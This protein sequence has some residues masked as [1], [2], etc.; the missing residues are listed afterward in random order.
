MTQPSWSRVE[1]LD[2]SK[3]AR[4]LDIDG[5]ASKWTD[6]DSAAILRHQLAAP[7]L[8][9]LLMVP[10]AEEP[11]LRSLLTGRPGTNSFL[12]QLTTPHPSLEL[13]QAI[14]NF[15]RHVHD[16]PENPLQGGPSDVLYFASIAA[17]FA[18]CATRITRLENAALH[19]G[20][21]WV[22]SQIGVEPLRTS[23]ENAKALLGAAGMHESSS[24]PSST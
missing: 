13:L 4:L 8:P 6:E 3:L 1:N 17:A 16:C 21:E 14:K 23:I 12:E 10:G 15:A 20:F 9:D 7:L 19:A 18:R 22:L 2:A 24:N 11:R 5:P